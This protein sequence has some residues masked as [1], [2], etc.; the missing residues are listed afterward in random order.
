MERPDVT[1]LRNA[2]KALE[3]SFFAAEND[4]LLRSLREQ[5]AMAERRAA[6]KEALNV[7]DE[8]VLDAL[9]ALELAPETVAAFSVVPLVEV[10]WADG[11]I[12]SK[13]RAAILKAAQERGVTEGTATHDLLVGWLD[14][15]PD[16]VLMDTWK[17]YAHA[18]YGSLEPELAA[19]LKERMLGRT[20]ALAEAAGGFLGIGAI[21]DAE[22]AVLDELAKA[23]S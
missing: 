3:E 7:N 4:R 13:E 5:A 19:A 10:A 23:F 17:A 22:R 8:A 11:K 20:R 18:L 15:K 12:Q 9:V 1:G 14:R 16:Q 21:S 6:F 2:G